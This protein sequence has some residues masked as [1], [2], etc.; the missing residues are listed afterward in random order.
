MDNQ[1]K[2]LIVLFGI[3]ASAITLA[4]AQGPPPLSNIEAV[5][6]RP[7]TVI[8]ETDPVNQRYIPYM[9]K[10]PRCIGGY[11]SY[12]P[13]ER[14]CTPSSTHNVNYMAINSKTGIRE[15]IPIMYHSSCRG[16]CLKSNG[17]CNK[18]QTWDKAACQCKCRY[19]AKPSPDPCSKPKVWTHRCDC[20]CPTLPTKCPSTKEWDDNAC[21]CTCKKVH[22]A[23][24]TGKGQLINQRNCECLDIASRC[25]C[26]IKKKWMLGVIAGGEFFVL[27]SFFYFIYQCCLKQTP[28]KE[29][30]RKYSPS[31]SSTA[32]Y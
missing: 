2:I 5:C 16:D 11:K 17:T 25:E 1:K 32:T 26:L 15:M 18:F 30:R 27:I 9:I 13:A 31:Q 28:K 24:C 29:R 10:V 19:S 12:K 23:Q 7:L 14:R 4:Y 8:V 20:G 6:G 22:L 3:G 21:G